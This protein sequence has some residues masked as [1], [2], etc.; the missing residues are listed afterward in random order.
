VAPVGTPTEPPPVA[1]PTEPAAPTEP[2]EPDATVQIDRSTGQTAPE[3]TA[4]D[5]SASQDEQTAPQ[6]DQQ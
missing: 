6:E 1:T 2:A 3:P 5:R 4:D